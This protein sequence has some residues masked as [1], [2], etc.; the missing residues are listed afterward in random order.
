MAGATTE[1]R[2][3]RK[4]GEEG[5]ETEREPYVSPLLVPAIDRV[6]WLLGEGVDAHLL[7]AAR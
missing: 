6:M 7:N 5:G 2:A 1:G 4:E 3:E